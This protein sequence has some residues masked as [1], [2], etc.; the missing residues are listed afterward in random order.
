VREKFRSNAGL[1]LPPSDVDRLES[2]L[3]G[4]DAVDDL[5]EALR[6]LGRAGRQPQDRAGRSG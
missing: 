4:L 1:A 3:L 2:V 5:P 6:P